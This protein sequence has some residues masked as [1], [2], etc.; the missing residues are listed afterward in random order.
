MTIVECLELFVEERVYP[1]QFQ[2][3]FAVVDCSALYT[4]RKISERS[5]RDAFR[6]TATYIP[7]NLR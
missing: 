3:M 6:S 7:F 1:F 5:S 4:R 2:I